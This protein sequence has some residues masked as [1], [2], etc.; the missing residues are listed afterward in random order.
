MARAPFLYLRRL[1]SRQRQFLRQL[2]YS[3]PQEN[4]SQ[5]PAS[6]VTTS[7]VTVPAATVPRP[8][9]L[10][11]V[12]P[13]L[14][15]LLTR[16]HRQSLRTIALSDVMKGGSRPTLLIEMGG[17]VILEGPYSEIFVMDTGIV[18]VKTV[19]R[20]QIQIKALRRSTTFIHIGMMP[21][22]STI[23]LDVVLSQPYSEGLVQ[24]TTSSEHARPFQLVYRMIG[25]VLLRGQYP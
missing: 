22:E 23:Y 19:S 4:V 3:L 17:S 25:G 13:C 2:P 15:K 14:L 7:A 16:R 24:L 12:H 8:Q 21:G 9:L 11:R 6:V 10:P 1:L 20:D 5:E 18:D